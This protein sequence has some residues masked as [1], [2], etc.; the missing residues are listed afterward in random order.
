M[1]PSRLGRVVTIG[2]R[3]VGVV[4]SGLVDDGTAGL[5]EDAPTVAERSR[6]ACVHRLG[7]R[8]WKE[9]VDRMA[10]LQ[11]SVDRGDSSP[12]ESRDLLSE[13][14]LHQIELEVQNRELRELQEQLEASLARY[15]ELYDSAPVGYATLDLEGGIREI[16]L[17][18]AALLRLPRDQCM[19]LPIGAA[20]HVQD[21]LEFLSFLQRARSSGR[22]VADFEVVTAED[23]R[24]IEASAH[25]DTDPTG[26]VRGLKLTLADVTEPRRRTREIRGERQARAEADAA[27]RMKDQFLGTVS[28]ELRTPLTAILGWTKM[29]TDRSDD[30]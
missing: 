25:A 2:A 4:L 3:A 5:R 18:G 16:N 6:T 21:G 7:K 22:Q 11:Q 23:A 13:L 26:D 20:L 8:S 14:Q 29:L 9:L 10:A 24:T 1:D 28:H 27:S 12:A 15:A 19:G 30:P 17:T